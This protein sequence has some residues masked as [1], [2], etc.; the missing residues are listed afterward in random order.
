MPE[1]L[2]IDRESHQISGI[3]ASVGKGSLRL[4]KAFTIA[5]PSD[6]ELAEIEQK[7]GLLNAQGQ[8]ADADRDRMQ[9]AWLKEELKRQKISARQVLL[10]L[11]RESTVVRQLDVPDIDENELADIVRLQAETKISTSLDQLRLDFLPLPKRAGAAG[12]EVLMAT[13]TRDFADRSSSFLAAADLETASI[14]VSSIATSEL[15]VRAEDKR[16]IPAGDVSLLLARNGNRLE[17]SLVRDKCLLFTHGAQ[18]SVD[19][20]QQAIQSMLAEVSRS[21]MAMQRVLG[22]EQ[23]AR[24]WVVGPAESSAELCEALQKRLTCDVFPLEPITEL[25]LKVDAGGDEANLSRFAG[26]LGML[27]AKSGAVTTQ[28][29]FLAPRESIKRMDPKKRQA[30]VIGG[31]V[32]AAFL[33]TIIGARVYISNLKSEISEKEAELVRLKKVVRDGAPTMTVHNT[34]TQWKRHDVNTLDQK[35]R[36]IDAFPG[37]RLVYF[38]QIRWIGGKEKTKLRISADGF[39]KSDDDIDSMKESLRQA[40]YTVMPSGEKL[41]RKDPAYPWEF[42]LLLELEKDKVNKKVAAR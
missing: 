24:A 13:V 18:L 26:P 15:V 42:K 12:R 33:L 35:A 16:G 22:D 3:E 38:K 11:P 34:V 5:L 6:A 2:A 21:F 19:S 36:K 27:L 32:A 37:T 1:Y 31:A 23:V 7:P 10:C 14:G 25:D 9:G 41:T 4:R 28:L 17:I 39:A 30:L 29:D 8:L 20:E 40:G